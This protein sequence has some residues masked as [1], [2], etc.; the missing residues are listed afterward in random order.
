MRPHL[1]RSSF[2]PR[3]PQAAIRRHFFDG[4]EGGDT[5]IRRGVDERPDRVGEHPDAGAAVRLSKAGRARSASHFD[6]MEQ[7]RQYASPGL[8][9]D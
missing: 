8:I 7:G 1:S 5:G 4:L 3:L 2:W 9:V 6:F